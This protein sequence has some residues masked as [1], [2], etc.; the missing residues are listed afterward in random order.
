MRGSAQEG[1]SNRIVLQ[2]PS[3]APDLPGAILL[4]AA[5][6]SLVPYSTHGL[7]HF[8][9]TSSLWPSWFQSDIQLQC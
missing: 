6:P 3:A 5:E 4:H 7:R 9:A 8:V 2:A 1:V